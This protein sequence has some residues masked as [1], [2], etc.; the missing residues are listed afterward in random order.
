MSLA[1]PSLQLRLT[2][3]LFSNLDSTKYAKCEVHTVMT[4]NVAVFLDVTS[5]S[6]ISTCSYKGL[7]GI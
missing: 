2:T 3:S 7:G 1:I 4:V 5:C 6:P